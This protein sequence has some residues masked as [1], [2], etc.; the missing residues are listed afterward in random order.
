MEQVPAIISEPRRLSAFVHA[1]IVGYSRLIA[2]DE[3]VTL[4]RL[5]RLRRALIDPALERYGGRINNTAG[6]ALLME[7]GSALSAVRFAV[8]VQTRVPEFDNGERSDNRIRFRMGINLGDAIPDEADIHGDSVNIA[9]RLQAICPPGCVCISAAVQTQARQLGLPLR[10]LGAVSLKNIPHPVDAYVVQLDAARPKRRVS[11]YL[12]PGLCLLVLAVLGAGAADWWFTRQRTPMGGAN[13]PPY[14]I[15][16]LPFTNLGNDRNDDYLGDGIAEDLTTDLSHLDG[17]LVVARE[18]AFTYRGKEVDIREVGR[19]LGVQYVV[20]GSVRRI[21]DAV[22]INAQLIASYN[23]A[24]VWAERFDQPLRDLRDGQDTTVQ[25]IGTAL[26]VKFEQPPAKPPVSD[27][28]AYDLILRA[29]AVL[30]EP[31]SEARNDIALGYFEQALRKDGDSV[32][33]AA[34]VASMLLESNRSFNRASDLI[35]KAGWGSPNSP[36][37]LA[38]KFRLLMRQQRP[39][40]AVA[41]FG[42]LLDVDSSAAGIGAS[43]MECFRCWGNFHQAIPLLER[44]ARLNPLSPDRDIVYATLG[45]MLISV[46]RAPEA[47]GWLE[48]GLDLI[49]DT[50][51]SELRKRG[52]FTVESTKTYLAAAYALSGRLDD[53]HMMFASAKLRMSSFTVRWFLAQ[54]PAYYSAEQRA[55]E[56]RLAEGLRLA[57][58]PDHMD[59]TFDYR[60]ASNATLNDRSNGPTPTTVPGGT[61]ITTEQLV[62]LLQ[63]KPLV[64][65]ATPQNPTIPGAILI[66]FLP[67]G[68]RFTDEWQTALGTLVAQATNGD[69]TKPIV[70]FSWCVERWPSRNLA[71]RLIALGYTNVY[72]YRGGWEAWDAH[73]LPKAP[74]TVQFRPQQ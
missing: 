61:T 31:R 8:E 10:P 5:M 65:A 20:E 22:R 25:H 33:A 58:V 64:L 14:S 13:G 11:R 49:S 6:D 50:P 32:P 63:Q 12:L 43:F 36:D 51:S 40:Q 9:A 52:D 16:V 15:A 23:G 27:P 74:L 69:K 62:Q 71:L 44:T 60:M 30:Q 68:G 55:E 45:R 39:E 35:A 42:H 19:Q 53:A 24:H 41:T 21:G 17:M 57:G 67:A 59:E 47:V 29:K 38:A 2:N 46:G 26:N 48:K 70:T 37:V 28:D 18:S 66:D 73:D 56:L 54:I 34:G 1:D 7:F 3:A 72:W 4:S